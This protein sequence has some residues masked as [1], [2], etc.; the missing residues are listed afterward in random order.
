MISILASDAERP[1]VHEFFE[2]FKTPWQ[3]YTPGIPAN[4]LLCTGR[5]IPATDSALIIMYN[6]D[7]LE[8][9]KIEG[10]GC[11]SR[12]GPGYFKHDTVELPV[13]VRQLVDAASQKI[14]YRHGHVNGRPYVRI[15][16][17]LFAEVRNL[18][19]SG[20]PP[21]NAA[22]P[23]LERHIAFLRDLIL[24]H[25][26]PLVEIPPRP[27]GHEFIACLTHDVDHV[28]IR[29]HKFDHTMFGFL[30]RAT[31]GSLVDV[32]TGKRTVGQ[33]GQNLF[34]AL[35]LPFVHL[36]LARDF[37][38][39]FDHYTALEDGRPSTF[40]VIPKK[41]E[42]GLD[43]QG[44]RM[45]RRAASYDAAELRDA[46]QRLES[47]GKEV[48]VHGLDAWRDIAA[49]REERGR[50][51]GL[52]NNDAA[53]IR[54]HWLYFDADAPQKLEAAGYLYDSTM[55]YNETVG[56][57]AGTVQAFKPLNTRHLLELPM[58]IMDTALFYP[59]YLNLSEK[60]AESAVRP[61]FDNAVQFGGVLTVNWHDRSLAPER[62]WGGF[63]QKLI[64]Q[65]QEKNAWFATAAQAVAW[66]R[67]RRAATFEMTSA[68]SV[69]I[70][71]PAASD[72]KLPP[73]RVTVFRPSKAAGAVSQETVCDGWEASLAA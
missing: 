53:G 22:M 34:A 16:F 69:K 41:G 36:G 67:K 65:L 23:V 19:T 56:Y 47:A 44:R 21:A 64:G 54:M 26:L 33:L 12:T 13:Y 45:P 59:S 52:V 11:E 62:L 58:H 57:R 68:G 27:A 17:D 55:G 38:H 73:L 72:D 28:G 40:Y 66:F 5:E 30:Y 10:T 29:N 4:I 1:A 2:L 7:S 42:A 43:A 71:L 48:T 8:L 32:C 51:G 60:Q 61:L 14:V 35:R 9:D 18:L 37:W 15:G 25:G 50:I 24:S 20:Q 6:S 70:K 3:F 46:L 63:Y 49:G 39:Q 31:A